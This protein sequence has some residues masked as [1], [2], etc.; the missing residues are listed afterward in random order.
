MH[1]ILVQTSAWRQQLGVVQHIACSPVDLWLPAYH[2]GAHT[3][4]Y[5][6]G[7]AGQLS[8]CSAGRDNR[9]TGS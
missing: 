7:P 5:G 3:P 9:E 1:C 6:L 2:Q 4:S 8:I